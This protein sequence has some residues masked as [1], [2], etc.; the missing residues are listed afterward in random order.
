MPSEPVRASLFGFAEIH[1]KMQHYRPYG[2]TV[3]RL[4]CIAEL[5]LW[6]A[7]A[8]KAPATAFRALSLSLGTRLC[9]K[10]F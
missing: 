10:T 7:A 2:I 3:I 9:Q 6:P 5:L 4:I 8:H 1:K